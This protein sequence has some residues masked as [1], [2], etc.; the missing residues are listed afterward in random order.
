VIDPIAMDSPL[1]VFDTDSL[2][3]IF[4]KFI[5]VGDDR[6]ISQVWVQGRKI[7]PGSGSGSGRHREAKA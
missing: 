4:Q 5:F 1:D 6:N 7:V 2:Q 3:E